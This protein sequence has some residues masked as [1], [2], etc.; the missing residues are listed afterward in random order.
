MHKLLGILFLLIYSSSSA[1]V[2]L[3][4]GDI[5]FQNLDCGDLCDAIEEVTKK[6]DTLAFSHIG[7]V[8]IDKDTV[9]IIEAI[10][11]DVKLTPL[12][13]FIS[14]N[15]NPVYAARLKPEYDS[16]LIPACNFAIQQLGVAYDDA[17]L[18]NNKKYYCS[19]LIYDAFKYANNNNDVFRLEPMTFKS[20]KTKATYQAWINYYNNLGIEIPE[21]KPGINPAGIAA[22]N[23][24]IWL[25]K[26]N[27]NP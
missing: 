15:N 25:G 27:I 9:W 24:L 20:P 3:K 21:G 4:S 17:F 10:G 22:S 7:L 13:T 11:S 8:W 16:M 5:L 23:L 26:L 19:E 6:H 14:R 12:N 2:K 1:Q 18:Y